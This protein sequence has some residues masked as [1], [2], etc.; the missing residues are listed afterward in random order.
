MTIW[1]SL[2]FGYLVIGAVVGL[3]HEELHY[4]RSSHASR[5]PVDYL[6]SACMGAILWPVAF[7]VAKE[8]RE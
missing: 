1:M 3:V 4:R 2:I 7:V 8:G 5:A 6:I